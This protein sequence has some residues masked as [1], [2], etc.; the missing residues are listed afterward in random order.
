MKQ[1]TIT[2]ILSLAV[3]TLPLTASAQIGIPCNGPDCKFDD[4][5][6]LAN[7]IVRFLMI[8]VAVPLAALGFMYTGGRLVLFQDKEGEWTKAKE[9]FWDMGMGFGIMLGSYVLIKAI[10]Y[11]FLNTDKGFTLFL[12]Q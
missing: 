2:Q 3:L 10:L 12:I 11:A 5:L 7:R 8:D 6:T 9:S 4:L 1:K